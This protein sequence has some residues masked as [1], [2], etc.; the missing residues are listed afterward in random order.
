M[1]KRPFKPLG[2]EAIGL[3]CYPI[4]IQDYET[5]F[6]TLGSLRSLNKFLFHP[7]LDSK[8]RSKIFKY[9]EREM[10]ASA[11]EILHLG[12]SYSRDLRGKNN[13][14]SALLFGKPK[15]EKNP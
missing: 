5:L 2:I 11:E 9:V 3:P 7:R 15:I 8:N 13:G 1:R 4:M 12:D 6:K 14:W 10:S